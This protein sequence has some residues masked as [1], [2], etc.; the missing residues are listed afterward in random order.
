[1]LNLGLNQANELSPKTKYMMVSGDDNKL[2]PDYAQMIAKRM[3]A[4]DKIAIASGDWLSSRGRGNQMPHGGGRF[5]RIA[6]MDRVGNY[7]VAY[8]WETWLL[9][10]AL[11]LGYKVKL[12]QDLRYEHLRPFRPS[13][14]FNWGR[15]M[16][17]LGF[18]TYFVILRF[19]INLVWSGRGTQSIKASGTMIVGYLS[20]KLSP[21]ALGG[22][23]IKD[24]GLKTFV[25]RL[26]ASRLTRLL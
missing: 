5:V 24:E 14:L 4:D 16:Y 3:D 18:P 10:K 6:F 26:S 19:L 13:N 15:A 11:Q 2:A 7:P 23:L 9:Y 12:Y 8:G 1:M 21:Q 22:M 20:A 17:S 25:R